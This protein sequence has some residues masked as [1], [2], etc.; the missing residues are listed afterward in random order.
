MTASYRSGPK[1]APKAPKPHH[2]RSVPPHA[3]TDADEHVWVLGQVA[4]SYYDPINKTLHKNGWTHEHTFKYIYDR[5]NDTFK[6]P[7]EF[8]RSDLSNATTGTILDEQSWLDSS[9]LP[10]LLKVTPPPSDPPVV[11]G[12]SKKKGK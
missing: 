2:H 3:D 12:K 7:S 4:K 11:N 1:H 9:W 5:V 6:K 8:G 10:M